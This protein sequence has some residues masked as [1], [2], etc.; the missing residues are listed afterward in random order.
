MKIFVELEYNRRGLF[1]KS[2][3]VN[4]CT[5]LPSFLYITHTTWGCVHSRVRT[6]GGGGYVR[7]CVFSG[8][9][10]SC[11]LQYVYSSRCSTRH[12]DRE[13]CGKVS[14]LTEKIF[15]LRPVSTAYLHFFTFYL[16]LFTVF[17]ILIRSCAVLLLGGK[18][19]HFLQ[20]IQQSRF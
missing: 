10:S 19:S 3:R 14:V 13:R 11:W 2:L 17:Y 20:T 6:Y 15:S 16:H 18:Q 8:E 12:P 5:F 7:T 4:Q 1:K 9:T